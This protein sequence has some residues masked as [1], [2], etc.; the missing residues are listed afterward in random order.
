MFGPT[1]STWQE[2]PAEIQMKPGRNIGFDIAA[3]KRFKLGTDLLGLHA[4]LGLSMVNIHSNINPWLFVDSTGG[5]DPAG[6]DRRV[7]KRNKIA[8]TYLEVPLELAFA[9]KRDSSSGAGFKIAL[10][11][12]TGFCIDAHTKLVTEDYKEKRKDF[13][14]INRLRYGPT[15]RI[16]YGNFS[17]YGRYDMSSTFSADKAPDY[18]LLTVGLIF[19]GF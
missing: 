2:Y 14:N 18:N 15:A 5:V 8:L 19:S 3:T 12:R 13:D 1:W 6:I 9:T 16:G 4:G 7:Y 17:L 10:G 11:W